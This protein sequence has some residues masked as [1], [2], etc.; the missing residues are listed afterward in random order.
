MYLPHIIAVLPPQCLIYMLS[1]Y[2]Y[3]DLINISKAFLRMLSTPLRILF[4]FYSFLFSCIN[5]H[6]ST[7]SSTI[8]PF[9][10]ECTLFFTLISFFCENSVKAE[11][12]PA[13]SLGKRQVI[14]I[15]G[16]TGLLYFL[17]K[18]WFFSEHIYV[19]V[20]QTK[21]YTQNNIYKFIEDSC[22]RFHIFTWMKVFQKAW[23]FISLSL[24]GFV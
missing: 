24:S 9:S 13:A 7:Y 23:T 10:C 18:K 1:M 15:S 12:P 2:F 4:S 16:T 22:I 11:T 17:E 5:S 6:I 3:M 19:D 14:Q 8:R 21:N 20:K